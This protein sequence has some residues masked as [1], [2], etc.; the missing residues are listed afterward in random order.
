MSGT[1]S[2]PRRVTFCSVWLCLLLSLLLLELHISV[3]HHGACQLVDADPLVCSESQDVD[4]CLKT[5]HSENW[6]KDN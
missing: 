4:G 6:R 3:M 1:E 2:E 5:R